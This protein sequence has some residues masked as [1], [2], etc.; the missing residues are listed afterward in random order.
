MTRV[1][2]VYNNKGIATI[3]ENR[4]PII[5]DGSLA[6]KSDNKSTRHKRIITSLNECGGPDLLTTLCYLVYLCQI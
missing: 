1:S 5:L 4:T 2:N 6:N 3:N